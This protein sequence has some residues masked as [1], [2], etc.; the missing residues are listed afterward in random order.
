MTKFLVAEALRQDKPQAQFAPGVDLR[1]MTKRTKEGGHTVVEFVGS[2]DFAS[3]FITRQRYEVEAGRLQVPE[4]W[5]TIYSPT[6]DGNLPKSVDVNVL[7]PGGVILEEIK[8]GGEVKFMTVGESTKAISMAH[9]AVGLEYHEDLFIYNQTW[10]FAPIERWVGRAYNALMNNIHLY[11]II[12]AAYTSAN[13]TAADSSGATLEE[14][15]L[16]TIED[17]I[18]ASKTDESNPRYGPYDLMV[19]TSDLFMVERALKQR[20]QA[21]IDVQSS[22]VSMVQNV[23]AYDGVTLTRGNKSVTYTGVTAGTAYLISKGEM[24]MDF[25]SYFNH[26][27]RRSAGEADMSR[28][29]LEQEIYDV[30]VGVY[31]NPLAA[32]EELTWPTS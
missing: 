12:A 15:Y 26:E 24:D 9:Y 6:V 10:R 5:R 11:P 29:I 25:Q 27:L 21:G 23:I 18:T 16:R 30:R 7:G 1:Q 19:S 8:E 20:V 28:F 2:G 22:A 4:L 13:Q 17:A 14:K 32:V 31:S 3:A